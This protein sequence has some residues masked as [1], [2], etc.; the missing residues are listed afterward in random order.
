MDPALAQAAFLQKLTASPLVRS[1][2]VALHWQSADLIK[3]LIDETHYPAAVPLPAENEMARALGISRPTLRQAMSR[4]SSEGVVHSQRGVGAFAL[5]GSLVRPVGL[6]S[7]FRDLQTEGRKPTTRVLQ[8]ETVA[9][10]ATVAT[11]LR[12]HPGDPLL[13]LERVRFADGAPVVLTRSY[14]ALPEG[15]E[16]TREQLENDGLYNVLHRV[17][18]IELVGGSQA[19]SARLADDREA[20]LLELAPGSAVMVAHRVAFDTMGRG[21]EYVHIIYPEGTELVSDLRGTS[22]RAASDSRS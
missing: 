15:V 19:I 14:L 11:E 12:V 20:G 18:G 9:A 1:G 17:G 22:V 6:S 2:G 10:D 3:S 4:L 13:H 8:F 7:L 16:L 5:R 21:I